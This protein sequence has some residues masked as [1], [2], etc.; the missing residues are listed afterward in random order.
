MQGGRVIGKWVFKG[1]AGGRKLVGFGGKGGVC[2]KRG[3]RGWES[4]QERRKIEEGKDGC[5]GKVVIG[6]GWGGALS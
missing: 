2:E 1:E 3:R 6:E 4:G 5:N